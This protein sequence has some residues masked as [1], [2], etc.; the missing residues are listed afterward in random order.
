MHAQCARDGTVE[1][2]RHSNCQLYLSASFGDAMV[3]SMS[4]NW[5]KDGLSADRYLAS[6]LWFIFLNC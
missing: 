6:F 5:G 2:R 3:D 1:T 4:K